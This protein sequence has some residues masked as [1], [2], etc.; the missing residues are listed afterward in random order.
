ML[1]RIVLVARA[2]TANHC[3]CGDRQRGNNYD[4]A[5]HLI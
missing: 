1:L 5:V 4:N 2:R 3:D